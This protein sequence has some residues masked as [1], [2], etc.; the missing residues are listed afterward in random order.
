MNTK[1][2]I[3]IAKNKRVKNLSFLDNFW[4]TNFSNIEK[5]KLKLFIKAHKLKNKG[6][7][8]NKI[9]KKLNKSKSSIDN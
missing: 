5:E 1:E 7:S 2:I 9:S 6:L 4:G 8:I 3:E